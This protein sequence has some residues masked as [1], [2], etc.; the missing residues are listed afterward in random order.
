MKVLHQYHPYI[1]PCACFHHSE[2]PQ[3]SCLHMFALLSTAT[4]TLH[5][6]SHTYWHDLQSAV[7]H[8]RVLHFPMILQAGLMSSETVFSVF[9]P[10]FLFCLCY[11]SCPCPCSWCFR[12]CAL[13]LIWQDAITA[14]PLFTPSLLLLV[15]LLLYVL[16]IYYHHH[17]AMMTMPPLPQCQPPHDHHQKLDQTAKLTHLHS[18]ESFKCLCRKHV[19]CLCRKTCQM[20]G[21]KTC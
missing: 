8:I 20:S 12:A 10:L 21:W 2:Q 5:V 3:V 18:H 15:S 14:S 19:K 1:S 13:F 16:D 17:N 7:L 6:H 9:H 11:L 4:C